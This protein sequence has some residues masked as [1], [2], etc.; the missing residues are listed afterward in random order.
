MAMRIPFSIL[1]APV[2]ISLAKKMIGIGSLVSATSP[3]LKVSLLQA[4]I[5]LTPKE[6]GAVAFIVAASNM[7]IFGAL[8]WIIGF[9]L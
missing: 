6:Y 5:K 1:P 9:A 3:G 2:V 4:D 8:F 7:I